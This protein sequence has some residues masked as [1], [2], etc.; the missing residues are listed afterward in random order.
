[1]TYA[2][3]DFTHG[4]YAYTK[5]D[6]TVA[7]VSMR[8]VYVTP[9]GLTLAT[10]GGLGAPLFSSKHARRRYIFA[11]GAGAGGHSLERH[12]PCSINTVATPIAPGTIDG[13]STWELKGYRGEQDRA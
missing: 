4:K 9:S 6:T 13:V 12:F 1:M 8:N 7:Q 10:G 2:I 11:L 3:T 5:D